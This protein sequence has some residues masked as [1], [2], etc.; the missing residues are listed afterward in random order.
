M[1]EYEIRPER[2][3]SFGFAELRR[4]SEL[5]YF[6]TW[7]DIKVKY[8]QAALGV[9]W[10]IFQP[11]LMMVIF[12]FA[13]RRFITIND[14][15]PYPFFAFSGLILWSV[16]SSGITGSGNS[17]VQNANIIKKI[18]FPRLI[19]P[20]SAILVAV[21]DFL[22]TLPVL[23]AMM[24]YYGISPEWSNSWM[25]PVA[26]LQTLLATLGPGCLLAALNVK[27]RDFRYIVPFL[28]QFL[29]F[30]TP[31]IYPENQI[32]QRWIQELL[33]VNPVSG[34][35]SLFRAFLTGV[36]PDPVLCTIS[37]VSTVIFF[38]AGIY[39][40]RKTESYFADLA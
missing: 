18:Y 11:L 14:T 20:F 31:V 13:F 16:F 22:M 38:F 1:I 33:A 9:L 21:F 28:V 15:V 24:I 30:A 6:F 34:A 29:L 40:F 10:A 27:Y 25:L 5:L 39:Y 12:S 8:K 3:F 37:A 36:A 32:S 35:I 17:M 19:I 7:R 23:A 26:L 2:K 4:H